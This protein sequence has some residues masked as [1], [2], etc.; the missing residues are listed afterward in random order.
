ME[1]L[2][3]TEAVLTAKHGCGF[4][5]WP[6]NVTLPDGRPYAY[7][8][9]SSLNVLQQFTDAMNERGIGHGFYYSLT[10]NF[11][12]N[13]FG[14]TVS[15]ATLLPNQ[16]KVTQSEWETIA[17]ASI[18]ELWTSFGNLT[19]IWL[20]GGFPS[21]LQD[22]ITN[23]LGTYQPDALVLN[24]EGAGRSSGRWSG[25]EG[26][27]PPNWPNSFST[28][29]CNVT[30]PDPAHACEGSGCP[31]ND[32][33]GLAF[34]AS[35]STDYT[36]Q[37]NDVWFF[38]P[39]YPLRSIDELVSTYHATV[40]A[41]AVLELDFA[42]DR[43]GNVA[44]DHAALYKA[45]GDWRRSCYGNPL[46]TGSLAPGELSVTVPLNANGP[47]GETMDRI[48]L[49]EGLEADV[50]GQCVSNYTLEVMVTGA[51]EW[52]PFGVSGAHLIGY[53]RIE[54]NSPNPGQTGPILN[55]TAVRFN[56]TGTY[57]SPVVN[58]SVFAP[59]P[60]I[61]IPP[62][63]PAPLSQVRFMYPDGRCLCTNTT[64]PCN[65]PA[66][67]CPL[68]LGDCADPGSIWDDRNNG[69]Y[70]VSLGTNVS[71]VVNIDC[72]ECSQHALAKIV[73]GSPANLHFSN[74]QIIYTCDGAPT[75]GL[76][77]SG[78]IDSNPV[79][80]C[81]PGEPYLK[82]QVQVE[83]CLDNGTMGWTRAIV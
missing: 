72:N 5:I 73:G 57:C 1:N 58:V 55:A 10:N 52:S 54:L 60:C 46:A 75:G 28:T 45:F 81:D 32:P 36:L 40:G 38:E 26:D 50:Y 29:C 41:N 16:E 53:K 78:G 44:P 21:S 39:F 69:N 64:Y 47:A 65:T 25:T 49:M 13:E 76:C 8:V 12:L 79:P 37:A 18:T 20:D 14:F 31:P 17:I 43:T 77:L 35:S 63:P 48:V 62:P 23:L 22:N 67:S 51:T 24:G 15:N 56:V 59:G 2:G 68:F 6:T 9:N 80:P 4:Y 74:G 34:Y 11:Y 61:P 30:A 66:G 83:S 82:Q 27:V 70:F 19:E 7:K 71:N 3:V 33:S 42:I